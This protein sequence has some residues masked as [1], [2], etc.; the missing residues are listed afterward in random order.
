MKNLIRRKTDYIP[1]HFDTANVVSEK[2]KDK[3]RL[4]EVYGL[5]QKTDTFLL[6]MVSR[7]SFQKGFDLVAY[8]LDEFLSVA[9]VQIVVLGNR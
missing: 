8:I 7:M 1:Y 5:P 3:A 6:G 9:Q 4:Q 2:A